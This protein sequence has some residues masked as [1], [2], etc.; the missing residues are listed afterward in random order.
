MQLNI[1]TNCT[2]SAPSTDTI[3][4][5]YESFVQTFGEPQSLF[6]YLDP[7]PNRDAYNQ[8]LANL[9]KIFPYAIIRTTKGLADGYIHSLKDSNQEYIFQ[10]EHDWVFNTHL[11]PH[12][13]AEITEVMSAENICYMR[14]NRFKNEWTQREAKWQS[15]VREKHSDLG[16]GMSY[17]ETD[18]LSN[19]PHIINRKYYLEH[20]AMLINP[21]IPGAGRIEEVLTRK[22]YVG[23]LYGGLGYAPTIIH[24]DGRKGGAK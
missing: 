6:I 10:L 8:Y 22:G 5:T 21:D 23:G 4:R 2:N 20:F 16:T 11:I 1:F 3:K 13:F 19:N 12:S 24:T 17:C 14:F 18:N 9:I 7:H 15:F